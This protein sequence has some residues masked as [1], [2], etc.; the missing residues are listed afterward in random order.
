MVVTL[1]IIFSLF[2]VW[3]LKET[4]YFSIHLEQ[5]KQPVKISPS[6]EFLNMAFG[7]LSIVIMLELFPSL[8]RRCSLEIEKVILVSPNKKYYDQFDA[9]QAKRICKKHKDWS[10]E[11][12]VND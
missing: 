3:L 9:I 12:A 1:L 5:F 8:I 10:W 2:F 6:G 7:I 11:E 4:H